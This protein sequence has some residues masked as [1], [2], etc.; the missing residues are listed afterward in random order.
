MDYYEL[1]HKD[2]LVCMFSLEDE[3]VLI[4]HCRKVVWNYCHLA[5]KINGRFLNG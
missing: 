2:D 5:V 1:M 3:V 4:L